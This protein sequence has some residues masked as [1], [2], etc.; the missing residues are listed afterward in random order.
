MGTNETLA[1]TNSPE[2]RCNG[3]Y[4]IG[5]GSLVLLREVNGKRFEVHKYETLDVVNLE[6]FLTAAPSQ[7][8]VKVESDTA[9]VKFVSS[10]TA[11]ETLRANTALATRF[12]QYSS[13]S[14]LQRSRGKVL[15]VNPGKSKELDEG[16]TLLE[17][18]IRTASGSR[19]SDRPDTCAIS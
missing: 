9:L 2:R 16:K 10:E 7:L 11:L 3:L 6:N 5:S 15:F 17:A 12:Y 1:L 14:F 4:L 18:K 19:R 13:L 8:T